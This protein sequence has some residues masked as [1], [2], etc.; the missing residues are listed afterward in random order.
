MFDFLHGLYR[1]LQIHNRCLGLS[2]DLKPT[3]QKPLIGSLSHVVEH[4][5]WSGL[6]PR[7]M[8]QGLTTGFLG[9]SYGHLGLRV[10]G[11]LG[12]H[13]DCKFGSEDASGSLGL[14]VLLMAGKRIGL[15][16]EKY[17]TCLIFFTAS[18]DHYRCT[19]D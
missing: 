4:Q 11:G 7:P 18:T 8:S 12:Q 17:Q 14:H 1:P 16:R 5:H 9:L 6:C 3:P 10:A 2:K 15:G 19:W 13:V